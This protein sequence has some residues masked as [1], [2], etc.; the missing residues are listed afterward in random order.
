MLPTVRTRTATRI[1]FPPVSGDPGRQRR[2]GVARA[3]SAAALAAERA[4]GADVRRAVGGHRR[5]RLRRRDRRAR[6]RPPPARHRRRAAP[7]R[8]RARHGQPGAPAQHRLARGARRARRLHRRRLP[9]RARAGSSSWSPPRGARP[10]RSSRARRGP[11]PHERAILAAPH[12]RTMLIEPV[13]PYAQTCNILYPRA[14]LERL[15]GFDERAITG[16]D[17]G[18]SLRA[19]AAGARIVAAPDAVVYHAIESHTLPGI[20]RQN[21]K[22]RHLAYLAKRHPEFRRE[23]PAAASSGTA[24]TCGPRPRSRACSGARRHPARARARR[25]VRRPRVAASRPRQARAAR[26]ALSSCPARPCVSRRGRRHGRRQRAPP[27]VPAVRVAILCHGDAAVE[28]DALELAE[29]LRH[30]GH[31]T[32]L[33]IGPGYPAVEA[34]LLWRGFT[35]GLSSVPASVRELRRGDFDVAHAF[36]AVDACAALRWGGPVVFG[37]AEVLGRERAGQPA[38]APGAACRGR[39]RTA[40]RSSRRARSSG[41]RWRA[42][43][44]STRRCWRRGMPRGT[45]GCMRA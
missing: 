6:P 30:A 15:D 44:P 4:R 2:R 35:E 26:R 19:R 3:P 33:L 29:A 20:L 38:A 7:H 39:W 10:A 12:V 23:L 17:V 8:D 45:R 11:D 28:H 1:R 36:T 24:T 25:A 42:G 14:L 37:V 31:D 34:L 43:S 22:W 21:L 32:R 13:G 41:L 18:L 27:D 5:P 9:A 40:R 16:E